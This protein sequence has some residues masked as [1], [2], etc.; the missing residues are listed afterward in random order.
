VQEQKRW[1]DQA[2]GEWEKKLQEEKARSVEKQRTEEEERG[3]ARENLA[4]KVEQ[5]LC[6]MI[7]CTV[8]YAPCAD[9]IYMHYAPC[10]DTIYMHHALCTM[11]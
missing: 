4:K 10:A 9:T 2:L 5:V 1:H 11:R 7:P 3:I 6:M 8:H